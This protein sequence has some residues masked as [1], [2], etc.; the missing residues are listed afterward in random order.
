MS[1]MEAMKTNLEFLLQS[2]TIPIMNDLHKFRQDSHQASFVATGFA[3]PC[4]QTRVLR[5]LST[6]T[7]DTLRQYLRKNHQ[8]YK[9]TKFA[10]TLPWVEV[11]HR[12]YKPYHLSMKDSLVHYGVP[13][14]TACNLYGGVGYIHEIFIWPPSEP[15]TWLCIAEYGPAC[16]VSDPFENWPFCGAKLVGRNVKTYRIVPPAHIIEPIA[17]CPW[18]KDLVA[19]SCPIS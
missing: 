15:K 16:A 14:P 3:E 9:H 7:Q 2:S 12:R 1:R 5:E 17:I 18:S 13:K 11:Q 8:A 4:P 19:I 6:E 10:T